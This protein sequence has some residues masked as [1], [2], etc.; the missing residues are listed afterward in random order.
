LQHDA[1]NPSGSG[2]DLAGRDHHGLAAGVRGGENLSCLPVVRYSKGRTR[3]SFG[4]V[5]KSV[6]EQLS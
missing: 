2:E 5:A 4:V 3:F 1:V 6:I